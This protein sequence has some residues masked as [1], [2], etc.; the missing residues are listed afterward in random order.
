MFPPSDGLDEVGQRR[1]E[2]VLITILGFSY[3]TT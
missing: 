2:M 1:D 3:S